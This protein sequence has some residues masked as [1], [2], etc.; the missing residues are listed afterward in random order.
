MLNRHCSVGFPLAVAGGGYSLVALFGVF[1]AVASL[2]ADHGFQG[3]PASEV[4]I[5]GVSS[6]GSWTLEQKLRNCGP[7]A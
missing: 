5:P 6:C 1:I 7:Q 2:V 3:A 4:V